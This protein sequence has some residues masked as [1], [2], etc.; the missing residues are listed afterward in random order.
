MASGAWEGAGVPFVRALTPFMRAA[1][2]RAGHLPQA[3]LP[4]CLTSGVQFQRMDLERP[5]IQFRA[6]GLT[7]AH[8]TPQCAL[9]GLGVRLPPWTSARPLELKPRCVCDCAFVFVFSGRCHEDREALVIRCSTGLSGARHTPQVGLGS[10]L[11]S[12]RPC[13][14][15]IFNF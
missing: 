13:S 14:K 8:C 11:L 15:D 9:G 2:S 7:L 3:P 12:C 4:H 10:S 1:P 6:A 5:N